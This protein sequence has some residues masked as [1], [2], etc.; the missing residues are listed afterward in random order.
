MP[1]FACIPT[2]SDAILNTDDPASNL[3]KIHNINSKTIEKFEKSI[4]SMNTKFGGG[5]G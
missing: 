3:I 4:S 5:G 2:S 1:I